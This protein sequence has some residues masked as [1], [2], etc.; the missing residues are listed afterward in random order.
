[1]AIRPAHV[2][3][4]LLALASSGLGGAQDEPYVI[5][6]PA[7]AAPGEQITAYGRGFCAKAGCSPATI[8]VDNAAAVVLTVNTDGTFIHTITASA[9]L[10]QRHTVTARQTLANG[11]A[12]EAVSSFFVPLADTPPTSAPPTSAPSSQ[13]TTTPSHT[14]EQREPK[15][16]SEENGMA[17]WIIPASLAAATLI[18]LFAWRLRSRTGT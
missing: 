12:I 10:G 15:P 8:A 2:V 1:M 13:A 4:L 6:S 18:G 14:P 11:T 3:G 16:Q 9:P 7:T 5:V 17:W